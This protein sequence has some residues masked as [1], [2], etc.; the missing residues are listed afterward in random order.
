MLCLAL[1]ACNLSGEKGF[2]SRKN[3]TA[4]A[5]LAH[6]L[7]NVAREFPIRELKHVATV[8]ELPKA[9]GQV[10]GIL[11]QDQQIESVDEG[12]LNDLLA[13]SITRYVNNHRANWGGFEILNHRV[14]LYKQEGIALAITI[15]KPA[16]HQISATVYWPLQLL[17]GNYLIIKQVDEVIYYACEPRPEDRCGGIDNDRCSIT[18]HRGYITDCYCA[19]QGHP[20]SDCTMVDPN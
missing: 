7:D 8:P 11:T 5:A 2:S 17:R 6:H 19:L 3:A 1:A 9:E 15:A 13:P 20:R 16:N 4:P 18:M 10:I 12:V 14:L